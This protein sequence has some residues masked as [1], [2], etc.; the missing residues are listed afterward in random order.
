MVCA[1]PNTNP[2][3]TNETSLKQ[4]EDIY[5]SKAVCDYGL[6]IGATSTNAKLINELSNRVCG[7]KM[8]LNETFNA[9]KMDRIELWMRHF[10]NWPKHKP[11][12]CHAEEHSLPAVLF[13]AELYDR[14]VHI[15]HVSS[16]E[17]VFLIRAAKERG[18]KVT[19]EVGAHHLF[20]TNQIDSINEREKEVR[21][22]LKT[23]E[24]R[25][26]LWDNFDI[27]DMI[28]SDHAPHTLA[29]KNETGVPGFAGLETT[30]PLLLTAFKQ[31][32]LTIETI[33][34][35]CYTNPK[36]IFNLPDQP[37]TY[38]ECD[39]DA[40]WKIPAEM[41]FSKSKWTPFKGMDVCGVVRRVMLRGLFEYLKF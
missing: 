18:I 5:E 1:M 13:L 10:E 20:L 27:I 9:L 33:K 3:L 14:H 35:K 22:R 26:A 7:L 8:Y 41:A 37:D 24:D 15:C 32:L 4:I 6:Y 16:K 34:E 21:P 23:E 29:E 36:R 12:C 28:A 38:I 2:A 39:L 25:K 19:C 11:L 30:L 17:D 40:E 31:G